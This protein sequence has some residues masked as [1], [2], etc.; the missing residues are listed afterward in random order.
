MNEQPDKT[1][2]YL[3]KAILGAWLIVATLDL[4]AAI[5]Q[6]LIYKGNILKM[7]QYIASGAF[8]ADAFSG[9]TMFAVVGILFHYSIALLWTTLFFKIYSW[10]NA[11]L[12]K[13]KFTVGIAYCFFV[14]LIMNCAILPLSKIP[15]RPF[16]LTGAVIGAAIVIV[17]IGLPLSYLANRYYSRRL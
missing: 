3:L 7:L 15:A 16:N 10:I 6:T 8:G 4:I 5:I 2:S 14:W 9:G 17:A 12:S 13:N 1:N 11:S